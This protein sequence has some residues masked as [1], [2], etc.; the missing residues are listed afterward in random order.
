VIVLD[1]SVLSLAYRRPRLVNEEPF[2]VTLLKKMIVED[3]PLVVPGIVLQELLSGVRTGPQFDR[4]RAA[5]AAFPS[6]LASEAHHVQAAEINNACRREGI[7]CS[8]VDALIAAMTISIGGELL[9]T[10]ADFQ[11]IALRCALRLY[12]Q[13]KS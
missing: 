7:A 4:L 2:S 11:Q 12:P 13:T 9:T 8:T 5:M 6:L 10:D 3:W 1:T